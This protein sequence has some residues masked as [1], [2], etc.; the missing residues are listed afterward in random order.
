[1]KAYKNNDGSEIVI[2]RSMEAA[3]E[4]Y[5]ATRSVDPVS[6]ELAFD[7][8]KVIVAEETFI[9]QTTIAADAIADAAAIFPGSGSV[10]TLPSGNRIILTAVNGGTMSFVRW[11]DVDT[12]EQ[13]STDAIY[14]HTLTK[15]INIRGVFST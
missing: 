4:A 13:L 2:A 14:T 11:E 5:N 6:L 7:E 9:F 1:M 3:A 10:Y 12:S 15:N 8:G